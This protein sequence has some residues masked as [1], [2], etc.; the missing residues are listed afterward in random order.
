MRGKHR[1]TFLIEIITLSLIMSACQSGSENNLSL[2]KND[3]SFDANIVVPASE[4]HDPDYVQTLTFF[5]RFNSTNNS[6]E[7]SVDIDTAITGVDMPVVEVEPYYITEED[8]RRVASVLFGDTVFY[9]KDPILS[10]DEIQQCISRWSR[11]TSVDAMR[12]LFPSATDESIEW[13]VNLI[14]ENIETLTTA[15]ESAPSGNPHNICQWEFHRDSFYTDLPN[16]NQEN[17]NNSIQVT[18]QI[19]GITYSLSFSVRNKPDFKLNSIFVFPREFMIF[20]KMIYMTQFCRTSEPSNEQIESIKMKA[21][22]ILDQI[23][24]GTWVID[25]CYLDLSPNGDYVVY[26]NAVPLLNGVPALRL[27]QLSNLKSEEAFASNYYLSN[28]SFR[29]SPNG[30]LMFFELQSPIAIRNI[31]NE[32]VSTLETL[33]LMERMKEILSLSDI[34]AYDF[35]G[36]VD[37]CKDEDIDLGCSVSVCEVEYSLMRVKVPDTDER[38]YYVPGYLFSGNIEFY[39][40]ATK[41]I[42]CSVEGINLLAINAVDGS[43][44]HISQ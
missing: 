23:D 22:S 16:N 9:D 31:I 15:F 6:V 5:D 25:E 21:A 34:Y 12:E 42:F 7:F 40:K 17:D 3:G 4:H 36:I 30:D 24:L 8:A 32:N 35:N 18:T 43:I 38:Y 10:R 44:I 33:T 1:F 11:F 39:D 20:D 41:D 14:K 28:A 27:P 13:Q 29:F 26:V 2:S 19:D 37:V